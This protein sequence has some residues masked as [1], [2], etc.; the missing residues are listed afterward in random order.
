MISYID[1]KRIE[2]ENLKLG[3]SIA[4][5]MS[6]Y[7][8]IGIFS[9]QEDTQHMKWVKSMFHYIEYKDS[10]LFAPIFSSDSWD[11]DITLY[12]A[13]ILITICYG[14]KKNSIQHKIN[15]ICKNG[16]FIP[17]I[18]ITYHLITTDENDTVISKYI[19]NGISKWKRLKK[20][21]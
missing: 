11:N 2:Q 19:D 14:E 17:T 12:D 20:E 15:S 6:R 3:K 10:E 21:V 4:N 9:T 7:K 18:E 8:N 16:H 1:K 13:I 5:F